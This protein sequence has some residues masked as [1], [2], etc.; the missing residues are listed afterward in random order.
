MQTKDSITEDTQSLIRK[1]LLLDS[2]IET[3]IDTSQ[4]PDLE[5]RY[6]AALERLNAAKLEISNIGREQKALDLVDDV[7]I[8]NSHLAIVQ[9]QSKKA[10]YK[11]DYHSNTCECPDYKYRGVQCKH[12]QAVKRVIAGAS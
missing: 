11:V 3:S 10:S 9:S 4:V 5:S 1:D 8:L 7:T 6:D 2:S 12:I